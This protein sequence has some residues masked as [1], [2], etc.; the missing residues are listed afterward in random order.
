[1]APV[2]GWIEAERAGLF[3]RWRTCALTLTA[4][5]LDADRCHQALALAERLHRVDPFDEDA[6]RLKLRASVNCGDHRRATRTF[7]VA[8]AFLQRE[9]G[10]GPESATVELAASL[11][12]VADDG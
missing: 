11:G 1:M 10:I 7:E 4:Q 12:L 6:L 8:R 3:E 2:E 9:L 5:W